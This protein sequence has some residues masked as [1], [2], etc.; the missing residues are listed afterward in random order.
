MAAATQSNNICVG[1]DPYVIDEVTLSACTSDQLES[2][3]PRSALVST[4]KAMT[5][6][7]VVMQI[8]TPPTARGAVMFSLESASGTTGA[9][10][11]RMWGSDLS[12][13]VFKFIFKYRSIKTGGI[14][15][16]GAAI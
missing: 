8:T 7:E 11:I 14:S 12:G 10:G 15:A 1:V 4:G 5:A 2:V 16:L 3:V 6:S 13:G 9:H